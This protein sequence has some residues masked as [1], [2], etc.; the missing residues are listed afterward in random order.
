M[1]DNVGQLSLLLGDEEKARD[2]FSKGLDAL[3]RTGDAGYW[4]MATRASCLLGLG[5]RSDGLA[6]LRRVG[7]LGP[8]PS[9][10]DSIWRGLERLHQGLKGT[11]EELQDWRAALGGL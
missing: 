6:A 1:A 3:D 2:A 11:P 8:E 7:P 4:A 5:R 9:A 10:A